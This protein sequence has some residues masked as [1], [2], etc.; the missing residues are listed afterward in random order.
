MPVHSVPWHMRRG[1][2]VLATMAVVGLG[3]LSRWDAVSLPGFV[4]SYAGDTLW[5]TMVVFLVALVRPGAGPGVIAGTGLALAWG[6][7]CSQLYQAPWIN[8]LR[9]TVP[10]HLVLGQGFLW[11]DL[12]CHVAGAALG[13]GVLVLLSERR[14]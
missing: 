13:C 8:A 3:L 1:R 7:E 2:L 11:T 6:V 5:A 12:L 14:A 9:E 10:G 4:R